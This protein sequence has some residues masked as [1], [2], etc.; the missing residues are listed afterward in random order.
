MMFDFVMYN[1]INPSL[2][3][4]PALFPLFFLF[5]HFLPSSST[6]SA[7]M[8]FNHFRQAVSYVYSFA[9]GVLLHM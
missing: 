3:F 9:R 6:T 5:F 8:F 2:S 1:P 7:I 4:L